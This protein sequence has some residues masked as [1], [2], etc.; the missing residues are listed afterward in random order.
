MRVERFKRANSEW[1]L[2]LPFFRLAVKLN[3]FTQLA[4]ELEAFFES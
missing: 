2:P 1:T 4:L 3:K